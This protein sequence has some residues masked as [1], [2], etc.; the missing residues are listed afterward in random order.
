MNEASD[1]PPYRS[2]GRWTTRRAV[3]AHI[4]LAVWVPGC[5]TATW[6]QVSIAVSGDDIGW[7]YSVMWPCFAV[8]GIVFWWHLV[9]DDPATVGSRALRDLRV[10]GPGGEPGR[11]SDEGPSPAELIAQAEEEDPELAEYNAYLASLAESRDTKS[12]TRP[13]R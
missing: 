13:R 12:S 1:L 9:H 7:V 5:I 10:P 8:F 2:A 4:A 11:R 3:V 6:W